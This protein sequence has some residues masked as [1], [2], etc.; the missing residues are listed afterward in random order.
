S[1]AARVHPLRPKQ[2]KLHGIRPRFARH[3]DELRGELELAVVVA[4]GFGDHVAAA[5]LS[6]SAEATP[7]HVGHCS[8][9]YRS[10]LRSP[11]M[12]R[13]EDGVAGEALW[14]LEQLGQARR[15][16]DWMFSQFADVATG[17]IAEVGAG[18]GTFSELLL[19]APSTGRLLLVEPH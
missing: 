13:P 7:C 17:E 4:P 10:R 12:T 19:A 15:L 8:R 2:L 14:D 6:G 18:I 1:G 9:G 5:G 3:R 11:A 16:R